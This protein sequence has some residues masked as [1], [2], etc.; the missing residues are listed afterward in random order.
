M[1]DL[2]H[3]SC[4][5]ILKRGVNC[6]VYEGP[7]QATPRRAGQAFIPDWWSVVTPLVDYLHT[8][9]DV[10]ADK[11]VLLGDPFGDTL[12][13]LAASKEHRLSAMVLLDGLPSLRQSL[14]EQVPTELVA[15]YNQSKAAEF[16]QSILETLASPD[17][18]TSFK[19]IWEYT[20]WSV[21]IEDP[22]RAW[23]RLGDFSW[24]PATAAEIVDLPVFV[25]KGQVRAYLFSPSPLLSHKKGKAHM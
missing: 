3:V 24:S 1:Q 9:P 7:G 16:N 12:A 14:I 5:E 23:T 19:F 2:Y 4:S 18:A 10:D 15:L 20:F 22:Y 13:P 25:A 6:L 11:I 8:R 21:M 17:T